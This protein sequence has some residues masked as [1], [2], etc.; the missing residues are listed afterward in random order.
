[1]LHA[2]GGAGHDDGPGDVAVLSLH[3]LAETPLLGRTVAG[4]D[5]GPRLV[6]HDR[7]AGRIHQI[8]SLEA[9]MVAVAVVQRTVVIHPDLPYRRIVAAVAAVGIPNA[10]LLAVI[11]V[12][13]AGM[14]PAVR[15]LVAVAVARAHGCR[16]AVCR[17]RIEIEVEER[18][19]P[20]AGQHLGVVDRGA[21]RVVLNPVPVVENRLA[22]EIPGLVIRETLIVQQLVSGERQP[23][24][25]SPLDLPA[26]HREAGEVVLLGAHGARPEEVVGP[27]ERLAVPARA[28]LQ[29][30]DVVA[31]IAGE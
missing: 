3:R 27:L 23:V 2:E 15:P 12:L 31:D 29:P 17:K 30:E 4:E 26:R 19:V 28:D 21:D 25:G 7:L 8:V 16:A 1:M 18:E 6:Q 20:D 11:R 9:G 14:R 24:V 5:P 22:D 13:G 10:G